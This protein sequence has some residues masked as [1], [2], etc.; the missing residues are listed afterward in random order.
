ML[1]SIVVALT[2]CVEL[3]LI[4]WGYLR[5][6]YGPFG[7]DRRRDTYAGHHQRRD[8]GAPLDR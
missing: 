3:G 5:G 4:G 7:D 6:G 2:L 8:R 1:N